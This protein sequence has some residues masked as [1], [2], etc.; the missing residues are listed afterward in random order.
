MIKDYPKLSFDSVISSLPKEYPI[1]LTNRINIER[2]KLDLTIVVLDDDPTGTQTVHGIP[3]LTEWGIDN[4]YAEFSAK[5]DLFF[6]LTNSRSLSRDDA[7]GLAKEIG[8]NLL[9]ASNKA[10]RDFLVIS[11]SDSTLRG[12][13]PNEVEALQGELGNKEALKILIP[14][15]FESGRYTINDVHYVKE[16]NLLVPAAET[17]F[18][19]DK[20]FGFSNSNLKEYVEEKTGGVVK[21]D[22]VVSFSLSE[23]RIASPEDIAEK[24]LSCH[25]GDTC[26]VNAVSYRDLQVFALGMF[27]SGRKV[28][29][30][31][32]ASI[33]PVL[34]SMA[35]K[36]LLKSRDFQSKNAGGILIL[37]GS[38]VPKTTVQLKRLSEV[39]GLRQF[40][41]D[42]EKVLS[43][44]QEM[45]LKY[46]DKINK[47]IGDGQDVLVFTSRKLVAVNNPLKSLEIGNRVSD[48]LTALIQGL[49]NKPKCIMAKG[50]ITSSDTATKGLAV[51]KA[52]VLGQV[53]AGVPVW[54]LGK[55][56]KFPG[57]NYVILPGNVG[58]DNTLKNV[59]EIVK[60]R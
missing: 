28:L 6:I 39:E 15:F 37:V 43:E 36:P 34:L 45:L 4:I 5:S 32:A 3:V 60:G 38:Y 26:I 54:K 7:N 23:L 50:G 9:E 21:A 2:K 12:H 24:L 58:D 44:G 55:E 22:E 42:V 10:G 13:Y 52:M 46:R 51:K 47:L 20:V 41:V 17:P 14:A 25:E 57:M 35:S 48:F 19:K 27:L 40:E 11:R 49:S 31:T 59:Y 30:R 56:S 16:D 33:I 18:A 53:E 8:K 1:D 29:L